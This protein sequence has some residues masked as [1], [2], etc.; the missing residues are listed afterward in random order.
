MSADRALAVH[1]TASRAAPQEGRR[2]AGTPPSSKDD[3]EVSLPLEALLGEDVEQVDAR[4]DVASLAV[5]Q[6]PV[7]VAGQRVVLLQLAHQVARHGVD[8][9]R[10]PGRQ[11]MELDAPLADLVP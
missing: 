2:A 8:A 1:R 10:R 9:H 11:A 4:R 6:V 5:L 3:D 7:E